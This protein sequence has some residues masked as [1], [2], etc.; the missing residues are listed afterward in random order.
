MDSDKNIELRKIGFR[1]KQKR[2]EMKLT[3]EEYA[4]KFGYARSTLAKLEAGLRDFKSSEIVKF[5]KE[6]GVSAD[7]LLGIS[8]DENSAAAAAKI[9]QMTVLD[10]LLEKTGN[11]IP[12]RNWLT[13]IFSSPFLIEENYREESAAIL[14]SIFDTIGGMAMG[15]C[16]VRSFIE[17]QHYQDLK[18]LDFRKAMDDLEGLIAIDVAIY[19][20]ALRRVMY[21][22]F[23]KRVDEQAATFKRAFRVLLELK[24]A[25][26]LL[27][28]SRE[29]AMTKDEFEAAEISYREKFDNFNQ[30]LTEGKLE[31]L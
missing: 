30:L 17:R 5:T 21:T 27:L 24:E 12:I 8:N 19:C 16:Y 28:K 25:I 7:W 31:E 26:E 20:N 3:Q 29:V 22:H 14:K 2:E 15:G 4:D 9:K 13:E 6:L 10:E 1:I 18:D 23:G 11:E